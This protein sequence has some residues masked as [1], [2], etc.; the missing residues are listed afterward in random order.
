MILY[1]NNDNFVNYSFA[2]NIYKTVLILLLIT[3]HNTT[4]VSSHLD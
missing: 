1:R 3:F 2:T 4:D